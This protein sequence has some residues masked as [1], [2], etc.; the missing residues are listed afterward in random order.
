M[1]WHPGRLRRVGWLPGNGDRWAPDCPQLRPP[2]VVIA[3]DSSQDR[4]ELRLAL[5]CYGGVSLAVYM[6]GLTKEV[7]KLVRASR[8]FDDVEDLAA[9]NPFGADRTE[10]AYF[11]ALR[12]MARGGRRLLVTV[13]VIAGTSAGGINGVVLGKV[14]ARGGEQDR[15]RSLWVEEGDLRKLLRGWRVGGLRLRAAS[16]AVRLLSRAATPTSPLKGELMSRLLFDAMQDIDDSATGQAGL[17]P[18]TGSLDLYVTLTDLHGFEV[19][20]PTG[21]G[22]ASQ[23]DRQHAQVLRFSSERGADEEFGAPAT[24][25][26]AFAA[27]ATS[28]FPGAFAPVSLESFADESGAVYE[29]AALERHFEYPY[30]E[31]GTGTQV[32]RAADAW[33]VDGGVLDNAPF[34]LVVAA[35]GRKRAETQ[36]ERRVVYIQP[37]PGRPLVPAA[38][39]AGP[40]A[41]PSWIGGLS[42]AVFSVKGTHTVLRDLRALRDL[43][44]RIAEVGAIATSQM[45]AVTRLLDEL[46]PPPGDD[47]LSWEVKGTDAIQAVAE[48]VRE[49][50]RQHLGASYPSYCRLKVEAAAR[51]L[52]DEIARRLVYPPDSSGSSF[53]RAALGEWARGR[54]EWADPDPTRLLELLG[55]VDIPYRERRLL[56]LLAGVNELYAAVGSEP[57]APQRVDLDRLKSRAWDMLDQLRARPGEAVEELDEDLVAFLSDRD[58]RESRFDAP[59]AFAAKNADHFTHLY[60]HCSE[61]LKRRLGD[62]STPLW[63]AYQDLTSAWDRKYRRQLL[64]R[65]L[66]FP[67]WD[68]LIFPTVALAQLPQFTPI[69]VA[70]FSPLTARA[71][72]P[73]DGGKL[74]GVALHHFAAFTEAEWRE[75]DY[76]WGRLDGVELLLRTLHDAGSPRPQAADTAPPSS[77]A[78]A[79]TRAGGVLLQEGLRAVLQSETDLRRIRSVRERIA[80]DVERLPLPRGMEPAGQPCSP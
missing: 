8:A 80:E 41:A 44:L 50:A 22:G 32:A 48:Q 36:V 76:L 77:P 37:D 58:I 25:A 7:H 59:A 1:P 10:A 53:V 45:T 46:L 43:N 64:S 34:D 27:R 12:E 71:L 5:V 17:L 28:S 16:A 54:D 55:P 42:R 39:P 69:S 26:L 4:I 73:P 63:E 57:G 72:P 13:D 19:L 6:H 20:V 30:K 21:A 78:E 47:G 52:A 68:G 60:T 66:A 23:R 49:R 14:L 15:L 40:R 74:K 31:V 24:P 75:N 51:R 56:F 2:E 33:F 38:P 61:A 70:Q 62:G 65:Y 35:I 18:P 79:V 29:A 3:T 11:E 9:A 67:L